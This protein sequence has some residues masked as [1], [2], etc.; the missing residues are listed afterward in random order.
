MLEEQNLHKLAIAISLAKC[1]SLHKNIET[2]HFAS[3]PRKKK[4]SGVEFSNQDL[5]R[6]S[7]GV[8][9]KYRMLELTARAN[10]YC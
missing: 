6:R 1:V 8:R 7:Y 3:A 4:S 5:Q 2:N 9:S 10:I